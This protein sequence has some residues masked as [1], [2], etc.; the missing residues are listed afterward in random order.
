LS[1]LLCG[2]NSARPTIRPISIQEAFD[3]A[4]F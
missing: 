2:E 1:P 3:P 4:G